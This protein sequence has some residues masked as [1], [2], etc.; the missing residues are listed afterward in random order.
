MCTEDHF[1]GKK[2]HMK[3]AYAI[4]SVIVKKKKGNLK[5]NLKTLFLQLYYKIQYFSYI[6][7]L[8]KVWLKNSCKHVNQGEKSTL[9]M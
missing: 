1:T 8:Y 3:I 5:G 4:T 6:E 9:L 2:W 7:G